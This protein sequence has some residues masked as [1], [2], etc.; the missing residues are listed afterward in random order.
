MNTGKKPVFSDSGLL[1]T[2]GYEVEGKKVNHALEGS[3]AI[4]GAEFSG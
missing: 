1:T 3:I 4:T 2:V